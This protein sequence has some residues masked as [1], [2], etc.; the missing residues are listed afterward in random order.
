MKVEKLLQKVGVPSI[1][2]IWKLGSSHVNVQRVPIIWYTGEVFHILIFMNMQSMVG[3]N[4]FAVLTI[5]LL[6]RQKQDS[7]LKVSF[8]DLIRLSATFQVCRY[9]NLETACYCSSAQQYVST[10]ASNLQCKITLKCLKAR[11]KKLW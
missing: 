4:Y 5:C 8:H 9:G 10:F 6:L 1:S 2:Y 11:N 3:P 7:N